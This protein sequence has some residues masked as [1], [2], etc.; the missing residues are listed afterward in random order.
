M[1]YHLVF[2]HLNGRQGYRLFK[3]WMKLT[4]EL[5]VKSDSDYR[6]AGFS[7]FW[8]NEN[9]FNHL[10]CQAI[11]WYTLFLS[12]IFAS[13]LFFVKFDGVDILSPTYILVQSLHVIQTVHGVF[14]WLHF[15]YTLNLFYVT[16]M[17]FFT[18]RFRNIGRQLEKMSS[19]RTVGRADNRKLS[20]LIAE[21]HQVHHDLML[22]NEM[23][24]FQT[25]FNLI[26]FFAMGIT[27]TYLLLLEIDWR[28]ANH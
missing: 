25:G 24:K 15:L 7:Q 9:S 8:L 11:N 26:A 6:V 27:A 13:Q 4:M 16:C 20:R 5:P 28:W 17:R 1:S 12:I 10:W 21:H 18:K 2:N 19:S 23:F 3:F 14:S 22:I